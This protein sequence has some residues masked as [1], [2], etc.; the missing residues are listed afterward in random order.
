LIQHS[1]QGTLQL[2]GGSAD[3]AT[4]LVVL[5]STSWIFRHGNIL[6]IS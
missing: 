2:D 5:K 1:A 4:K 6:Q 3:F